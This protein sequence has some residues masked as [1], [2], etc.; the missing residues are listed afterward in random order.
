M[1]P[2]VRIIPDLV[3]VEPCGC[4]LEIGTDKVI[5]PCAAHEPFEVDIDK[6]RQE[7]RRLRETIGTLALAL[8]AVGRVCSLR[9][10]DFCFIDCLGQ[11][12]CKTE[13]LTLLPW[14]DLPERF[15]ELLCGS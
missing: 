14:P 2:F 8:E 10:S 1:S 5:L 3:R 4:R 13:G 12:L 11:V 7:N 6:L 15:K 9:Q